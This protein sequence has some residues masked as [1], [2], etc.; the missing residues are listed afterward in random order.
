MRENNPQYILHLIL[1]NFQSTAAISTRKTLTTN[2][3]PNTQSESST[4]VLRNA[5]I[6]NKQSN[7]ETPKEALM[8]SGRL[9]QTALD[10]NDLENAVESPITALDFDEFP[11]EKRNDRFR[12]KKVSKKSK[13]VTKK[14][15]W[16]GI[17][18]IYFYSVSDYNIDAFFHCFC[19]I[20]SAWLMSTILTQKE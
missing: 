3:S 2:R 12:M 7:D 4:E 5:R 9:V 17:I 15:C 20:F 1:L 6:S 16:L 14:V 13:L 8:S 10:K 19:N 18:I 11:A